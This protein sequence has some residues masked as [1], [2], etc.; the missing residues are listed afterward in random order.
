MVSADDG[1]S[2]VAA[3]VVREYGAMRRCKIMSPVEGI[4]DYV[5]SVR[6]VE[7]TVEH[8]VLECSKYEH[9][10]ESLVDVVHEQ[11]GENK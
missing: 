4:Q 2:I 6:G 3:L 1:S 7:Q 9:E 11:C 5:S 8:L 10:R